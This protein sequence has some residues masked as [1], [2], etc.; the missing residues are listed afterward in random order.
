MRACE[1]V[2]VVF[3]WVYVCVTFTRSKTKA[4]DTKTIT[5]KR[6]R[7]LFRFGVFD[8]LS[9]CNKRMPRE[10]SGVWVFVSFWFSIMRKANDIEWLYACGF[11]YCV[12]IG[13]RFVFREKRNLNKVNND[14]GV[15]IWR[16]W[17]QCIH[18]PNIVIVT[19]RYC[20][21]VFFQL[22]YSL[23]WPLLRMIWCEVEQ[24]K[25]ITICARSSFTSKENDVR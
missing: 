24:N 21:L 17:K 15:S 7:T 4:T 12:R 19:D 2:Y 5:T 11:V 13:H 9:L 25:T 23:N 3:E 8:F 14:N 18:I 10:K 6:Q 16:V 20:S 22:F 1:S